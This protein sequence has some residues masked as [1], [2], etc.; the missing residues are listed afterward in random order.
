MENKQLSFLDVDVSYID[1]IFLT[2]VYRKPT[3][4]GLGLNYFSAV[5]TNF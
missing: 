2:S 1:D 3:F 4:T 5:Y